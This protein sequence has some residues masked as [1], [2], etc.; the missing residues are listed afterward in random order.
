MK[1]AKSVVAL[2]SLADVF[3]FFYFARKTHPGKKF[4]GKGKEKGHQIFTFNVVIPPGLSDGSALLHFQLF[5][6]LVVFSSLPSQLF[7]LFASLVAS[8]STPSTRNDSIVFGQK[9]N[10]FR[11][12][13]SS[14]LPQKNHYV[15]CPVHALQLQV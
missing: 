14:G 9:T 1:K 4:G 13:L 8:Y 15:L 10:T 2:R 12:C 7:A 6:N 3:F 11:I 5:R